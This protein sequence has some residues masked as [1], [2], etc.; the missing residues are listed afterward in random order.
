MGNKCCSGTGKE[1]K[2]KE[3]VKDRRCDEDGK[4]PGHVK[5]RRKQAETQRRLIAKTPNIGAEETG[6][7]HSSRWIG[8]AV[9]TASEHD[10]QQRQHLRD[11]VGTWQSKTKQRAV[12]PAKKRRHYHEDCQFWNHRLI[13][14]T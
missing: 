13:T 1:G 8:Q 3:V 10:V 14:D 7:G 5:D 12:I 9:T 6:E 11:E 2:T 4:V